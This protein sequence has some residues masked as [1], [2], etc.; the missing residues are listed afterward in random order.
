MI[1]NK[2][3]M[4]K[5]K[6][7]SLLLPFKFGSVNCY[8]IENDSKYIL[9]N[10]GSSKQRAQLE[11]ELKNAGC[12]P[13]NLKLIVITHGDFDHTGNANYLS[14]KFATQIAMHQEDLGMAEHGDM[15]FNRKQP[16]ILIR[17]II[18]MLLGFCKGERF[19]PDIFIGAGNDLSQ[20]G[21][22][23]DII[24]IPGHSKGSI[25]I[26]LDNGDLFCGDLLENTENPALNSIMDNIDAAKTSIEKLKRLKIKTVYPGH[27]KA[28]L[29]EQLTNS[30]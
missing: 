5:I 16:N 19:K 26:L 17:K 6:T 22:D 29:M 11:K 15:F 25:G 4:T 3:N 20:Y 13:G 24:S 1:T 12:K 18:P 21:F 28:F 10:T 30:N 7:I 23:A 2:G 8:L 14:H 27:G 9:I